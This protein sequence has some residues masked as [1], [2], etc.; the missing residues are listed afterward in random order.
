MS[1]LVQVKTPNIYHVPLIPVRDVVVYPTNEV[2]LTFGR[3]KSILAIDKALSTDKYVA[4][5]TQK[6]SKID[7]PEL[8][9]LYDIVNQ[10]CTV[11]G[12]VIQTA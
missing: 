5:F 12:D 10:V 3:K 11:G 1:D 7:D 9:D 8:K 2:V 6:D 4:L